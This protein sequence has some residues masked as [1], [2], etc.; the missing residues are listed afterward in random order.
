M[1]GPHRALPPL[2]SQ[3]PAERS[4]LAA[5]SQARRL[6][7]HGAARRQRGAALHP[8]RSRFQQALC[9]ETGPGASRGATRRGLGSRAFNVCTKRFTEL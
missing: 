2:A 6:P 9:P 8:Q 3:G 1:A 7:H 5:R 4:G